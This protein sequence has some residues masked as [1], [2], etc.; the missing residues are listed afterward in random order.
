[1]PSILSSNAIF[2]DCKYLNK[3]FYE[4]VFNLALLLR[5]HNYG[6]FVLARQQLNQFLVFLRDDLRVCENVPEIDLVI[7]E[8]M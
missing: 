3:D 4:I 8:Q 2:V 6:L 7:R 1:M 5:Q